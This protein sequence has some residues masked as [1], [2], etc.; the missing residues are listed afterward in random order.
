MTPATTW[1]WWISM[2][3]PGSIW[4]QW[5]QPSTNEKPS[6]KWWLV[7]FHSPKKKKLTFHIDF[8]Q[9][10][11]RMW[12]LRPPGSAG[13]RWSQLHLVENSE[14]SRYPTKWPSKKA[15]VGRLSQLKQRNYLFTL[16]FPIVVTE[17]DT[18]DQ[19][20]G[21]DFD[22]STWIYLKT[23]KTAGFQMAFKDNNCW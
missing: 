13:F 3:P 15:V 21:M 5:K 17:C 1:R 9:C 4:K 7:T 6:K 19:L 12:H 14:N 10:S 18:C 2:D 20:E 11:D 8:S 16:I 22:G 23:V